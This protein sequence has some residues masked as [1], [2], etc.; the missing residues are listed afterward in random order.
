[1]VA[2]TQV[3]DALP[4][5]PMEITVQRNEELFLTHP[6]P[7]AMK[8]WRDWEP[9]TA[10]HFPTEFKPAKFAPPMDVYAGKT[11]RLEWQQMNNRQPFYH[12][13]MDVEEL[14]YQVSGDRT[15]M[16]EVGTAELR[17]GD[18]SRIPVGIAHDNFGRKEVH[19][20]LY[21]IAPVSDVGSR[22][23]VC[24]RTQ[25]PFE[26]FTVD[27]RTIEMVT[28]CLG[29]R[30]CDLAVSYVDEAIVLGGPVDTDAQLIVQRP[31]ATS[32]EVEWL[33]KSSNVWVGN[34]QLDATRGDIYRCHRRADAIQYQIS[35]TR[36]LVTQRGV[37]EMQPGDFVS[38]PRGCAYTTICAGPSTYMLVL[39]TEGIPMHGKPTKTAELWSSERLSAARQGIPAGQ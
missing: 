12:R 32:S 4:E 30:G 11:L 28:E 15:L 35:G 33:Y 2:V 25:T 27:H 18:F 31:A 26:G 10:I 23:S 19:L 6:T 39:S 24:E 16:T 14:S 20:L 37:L 22:K 7:T 21:T 3:F 8:L 34:V 13:N 36:T 5:G 17:A 1:M 9:L 29:A 38:V